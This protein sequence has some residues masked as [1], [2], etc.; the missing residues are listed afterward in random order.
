M[1]TFFLTVLLAQQFQVYFQ[2]FGYIG[3]YIYFVTIDQVSPI[4]EEVSLIVIGYLAAQ[5]Y[6]NQLHQVVSLTLMISQLV[7]PELILALSPLNVIL[8]HPY[9]LLSTWSA[10]RWAMQAWPNWVLLVQAVTW[11]T[12]TVMKPKPA[13]IRRTELFLATMNRTVLLV[14]S[15]HGIP[16]YQVLWK[17]HKVIHT[18]K[19]ALVLSV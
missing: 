11:S 10:H 8:M 9:M 3:I 2:R 17:M 7:L 14:P 19:L 4:P 18:A 6:W 5:L 16:K 1:K 15:N 13:A 12:A